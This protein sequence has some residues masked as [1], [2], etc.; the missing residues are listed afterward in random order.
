MSKII[1][2]VDSKHFNK[3]LTILTNLKPELIKDIHVD[4]S[5]EAKPVSSST[6][7]YMSKSNYKNKLNNQVLEDEFLAN[8]Q[9]TGKY[10]NTASYKAKL[11]NK[12]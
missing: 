9:S 2:D 10:L 12:K 6:G 4:K 8:K 11:Q 5:K 7:K 3:V 1:I